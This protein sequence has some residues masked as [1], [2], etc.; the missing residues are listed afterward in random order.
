VSAVERNFEDLRYERIGGVGLVTLNRPR[1]LNALRA[2][3]IDELLAVVDDAHGSTDLRALVLTGEGRGFCSGEDLNE[4]DRDLAD[5]LSADAFAPRVELVQLLARR[6]MELPIPVI[7]AVNGP[8]VGLGAELAMNCD[9]RIAARSATIGFPEVARGLLVTN[10]GMYLLPRL[11]GHGRA[12]ELLLGGEII[13]A[14]HAERIGLVNAVADDGDVLERALQFA[15]SAAALAPLSIKLT[16]R[17]TAG[18]WSATLDEVLD[19]EAEGVLRC[20]ADAAAVEGVTAYRDGRA[21]AFDGGNE[22]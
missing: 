17:I 10:A 19:Q 6:L 13:D 8:A 16:K 11:V 9:V 1:T 21:P 15:Q 5:G 7:A 20:I 12:L 4:L 18:S 22:G 2:R 14:E 3:S